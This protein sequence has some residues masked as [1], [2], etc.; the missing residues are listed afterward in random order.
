M[1][2]VACA[3]PNPTQPAWQA[4]PSANLC[5]GCLQ[6]FTFCLGQ[7]CIYL[8]NWFLKCLLFVILINLFIACV[9]MHMPWCVWRSED[10]LQEPLLF[11]LPV[12]SRDLTQ[13][14]RRRGS[15]FTRGAISPALCYLLIFNHTSNIWTRSCI[16]NK[17]ITQ[18]GRKL[19]LGWQEQWFMVL[20]WAMPCE[21][22][23]GT[24]VALKFHGSGSWLGKKYLK[25]LLRKGDKEKKG[26]KSRIIFNTPLTIFLVLCE[27][28]LLTCCCYCCMWPCAGWCVHTCVH[29][30]GSQPSMPRALHQAGHGG[31]RL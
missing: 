14:V 1:D 18:R 13:V 29:R 12:G 15:E 10:C 24:S 25:K 4:L 17:G 5:K 7:I 9:N 28:R 3:S 26:W 22:F 30:Y 27:N 8:N 6:G 2:K 23:H 20:Q 11:S 19:V 21:P 16:L 31:S